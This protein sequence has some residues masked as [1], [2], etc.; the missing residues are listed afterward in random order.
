MNKVLLS[1]WKPVR[2]LLFSLVAYFQIALIS[3]FPVSVLAANFIWR[4]LR[5]HHMVGDCGD[6]EIGFTSINRIMVGM[7]CMEGLFFLIMS[8]LSFSLS[9]FISFFILI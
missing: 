3:Y 1:V 8:R 9:L 6:L 5:G 2:P 4:S 7:G